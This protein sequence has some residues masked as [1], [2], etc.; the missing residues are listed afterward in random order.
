MN[1]IDA[2]EFESN[3]LKLIDEVARTGESLTITKDG[4]AVAQLVPMGSRAR[5]LIGL[6]KGQV[7][8][9]GDINAPAK[10]DAEANV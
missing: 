5:T 6:H 10:E 7:T 2:S 8:V 1:P 3:S 9:H 4:V